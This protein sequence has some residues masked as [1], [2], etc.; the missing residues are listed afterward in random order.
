M[1]SNNNMYIRNIQKSIRYHQYFYSKEYNVG[2]VLNI[3]S[4][5]YFCSLVWLNNIPVMIL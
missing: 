3:Y 1:I 2:Y 4:I 5:V